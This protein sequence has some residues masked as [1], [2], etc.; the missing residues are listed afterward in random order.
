MNDEPLKVGDRFHTCLGPKRKLM[1]NDYAYFQ[2]DNRRYWCRVMQSVVLP[3]RDSWNRRRC[4][5]E[6]TVQVRKV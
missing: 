1:T 4:R 2:K 5:C 3:Y 6:L